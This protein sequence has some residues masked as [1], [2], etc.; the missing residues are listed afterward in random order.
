M[1]Y[2][3]DYAFAEADSSWPPDPLQ[4]F[5]FFTARDYNDHV[6]LA[7]KFSKVVVTAFEGSLS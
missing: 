3:K 6:G 4:V 1:S 2:F 7:V 5:F